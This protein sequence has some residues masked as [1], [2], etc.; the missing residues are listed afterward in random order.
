MTG[1]SY[2]SFAVLQ[3]EFLGEEGAAAEGKK[4]AKKTFVIA[5]TDRRHTPR[6]QQEGSCRKVSGSSGARLSHSGHTPASSIGYS[7]DLP[8]CPQPRRRRVCSPHNKSHSQ[9]RRAHRNERAW[10]HGTA[11]RCGTARKPGETM[12]S[13]EARRRPPTA[14]RAQTVG[15]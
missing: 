4:K 3:P 13:T 6:K 5:T 12:E 15:R 8:T 1:A 7:Q 9:S 11:S 2:F 10:R 14:W